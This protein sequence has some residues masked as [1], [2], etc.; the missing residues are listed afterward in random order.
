MLREDH[1]LRV[2]ENR[3]LR[4]MGGSNRR[5]KKL[6]QELHSLYSSLNITRMIKSRK[7]RW[8]WAC[9]TQDRY[10]FKIFIRKPIG[11]RPLGRPTCRWGILEWVLEK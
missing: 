2:F 11:K 6:Y 8:V 10:V 4:I 5:L 7:M 1:I 3:V 9:S